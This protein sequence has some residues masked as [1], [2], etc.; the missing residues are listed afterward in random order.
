MQYSGSLSSAPA[1]VNIAAACVR[2]FLTVD[3]LRIIS[4]RC[5]E[6]VQSCTQEAEVLGLSRAGS[7]LGFCNVNQSCQI[8][9]LLKIIQG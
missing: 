6:L 3:R 9:S 4:A 5:V 8:Q 2:T 7:Q 1:T